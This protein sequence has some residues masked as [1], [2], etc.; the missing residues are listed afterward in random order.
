[1]L[2]LHSLTALVDAVLVA[3]DFPELGSDLVAALAGLQ[4]HDLAHGGR[5]GKERGRKEGVE[6]SE[7]KK[8]VR[9]KNCPLSFFFSLFEVTRRKKNSFHLS[10]C[11]RRCF[12]FCYCRNC[13]SVQRA[14]E[15]FREKARAHARALRISRGRERA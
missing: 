10:S 4:G 11:W 12:C 8:K 2:F 9:E 5:G 15:I 1:M 6:V 14:C 3:R 13:K 7:G